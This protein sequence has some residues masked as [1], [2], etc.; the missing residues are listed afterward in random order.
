M[1]RANSKT[2]N[3][4]KPEPISLH[5]LRVASPDVLGKTVPLSVA[6]PFG[7]SNAKGNLKSVDSFAEIRKM[8]AESA[9]AFKANMSLSDAQN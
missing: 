6:P 2:K 4:M 9:A 7:F 1:S 5:V 3:I 8:A